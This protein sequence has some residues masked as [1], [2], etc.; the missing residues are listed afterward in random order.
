MI[1]LTPVIESLVLYKNQPAIVRQANDKKLTIE[2][3][4][5]EKVSVRPKDVDLLHPGPSPH[6]RQLKAATG[7][8]QTAWEL[9]GGST[10]IA[11][12]AELAFGDYTPATAWTAWQL[13]ADGVY[14][15]GTPK[16]IIV[17]SPDQVAEIQAARLAKASEEEAWE[18]FVTRV[19]DGRVT[20]DDERYLTDVIAL[21]LGRS[22]SSRTLRRLGRTQTQESAHDLLLSIGRWLPADNPY[23]I[24]LGVTTDQPD[25][26]IGALPDEP[27]RDLT[28]L[29]ALAIDDEGSVDPDDAISLD[30]NR[31]WV[32]VADVAALIKPDSPADLEARGRA[33]NLYLPEGTVHMLP[34]EI[35]ERLALGLQPISPALSIA[36]APLSNGDFEVLE[37]TPSWVRV[38]RTTYESTE[39]ELESSPFNEL[40]I[41]AR[42][43]RTRRVAAGSVELDLPEVKIKAT[44]DGSV[45]IRPLPSLESREMVREL[46]LM[47]GEAIG[48]YSQAHDLPLAYTVQD[49]PIEDTSLPTDLTGAAP[50][51]MWAKRRLMQR[52]R[53]STSPGRH[54]GLGLDVYV[55]VTSP[56]RRYLDLLAHQQIRAY[57]AGGYPLDSAAVTLRIGTAD[58]ITGALRAA[59]R[60]SNQHWTL[61]FLMQHADWQGEGIVVENKPG[62]DV[63]LI[64]ALAWEAEIYHKPPRPL[65]STVK[66]KLES[67]NLAERAGRFKII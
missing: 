13:V 1:R 64:P 27:R 56:L 31:V 12:L 19:A 39:T 42:R 33:A 63:V 47:A 2:L 9:L 25:F 46:M 66:L 32:H 17:H 45:I 4:D 20:L 59:E 36:L 3:S 14:F 50:S 54:S 40:L 51:I 16:A 8:P 67:V 15:D 41:I 30:G 29:T 38:T 11:E 58:A 28:H 5:G 49:P 44:I 53:Q 21:A 34:G 57:L 48:R 26:A 6:P 55:Q 22:E 62:R 18:A 10:T 65:D 61:V 24:R 52:S 60:L 37:F 23:P 35:T 7:D 43:N